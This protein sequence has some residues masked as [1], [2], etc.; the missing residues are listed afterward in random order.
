[1]IK[2]L[3]SKKNLN[4]A[5]LQVF[6]N[7]GAG[8][9]DDIQVTELKSLLQVSGEQLNAQIERGSYQVSPIK[10]VEIPKSNGK[11]RLLGIPTV[12]DRFYQQALHQ[13]LQ[14]VFEPGFR[15]YS[16]GF[17]PKRNAHQALQQSL[18][19][20]NSGYQDILDIDLKSLFIIPY[21]EWYS[22]VRRTS[23]VLR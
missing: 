17:R 3:T 2:Q 4:E 5:Y 12:V 23:L 6:R 18:E 13:V 9:I 10:G 19:N 1:M 15:T 20:I 14:P 22:L 11:T 7:K 21:F 8:G 16:Y